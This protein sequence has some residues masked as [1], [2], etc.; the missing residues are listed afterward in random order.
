MPKLI[1]NLFGEEIIDWS[2]VQ[3][4]EIEEESKIQLHVNQLE[5]NFKSYA[6]PTLF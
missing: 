6:T 5:I 2:N 3:S 1:I 4:K